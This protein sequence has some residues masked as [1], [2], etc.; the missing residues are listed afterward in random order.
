MVP[1]AIRKASVEGPYLDLEFPDWFRV[2]FLTERATWLDQGAYSKESLC[3]DDHD[4]TY[5]FV[6]IGSPFVIRC[7]ADHG[8]FIV[9]VDGEGRGKIHYYRIVAIPEPGR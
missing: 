3:R 1:A 7:V 6:S 2:D 8:E 5:T 4:G 9:H